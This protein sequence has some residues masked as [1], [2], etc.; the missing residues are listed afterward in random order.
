MRV[1]TG[2]SLVHASANRQ[3]IKVMFSKKDFKRFS[4]NW[5]M[6]TLGEKLTKLKTI[7]DIPKH[8][9]PTKLML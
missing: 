8:S 1:L 5:L 7:R 2:S 3:V 4:G 6:T 9:R